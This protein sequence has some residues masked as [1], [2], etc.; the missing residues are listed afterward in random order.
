MRMTFLPNSPS[1]SD[2]AIPFDIATLHRMLE[3]PGGTTTLAQL[4]D[5]TLGFLVQHGEA[6]RGAI[7]VPR[8][9]AL[10]VEAIQPA[11]SAMAL[12]QP[13]EAAGN[14]IMDVSAVSQAALTRQIVHSTPG[15]GASPGT[16]RETLCLPLVYQGRLH[17]VAYLVHR[18]A[19]GWSAQRVEQLQLI[20]GQAALQLNIFRLEGELQ[21]LRTSVDQA[22]AHMVTVT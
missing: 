1:S 14:V 11:D 21:V 16:A 5:Y 18:D 3:L 6:E 19:A 9:G 13:A 15:T 8:M 4:L 12:G 20:A 2:D 17:G 7:L 22:T 10:I